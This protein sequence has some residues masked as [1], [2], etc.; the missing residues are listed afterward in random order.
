MLFICSTIPE[1]L[2]FPTSEEG[3][4]DRSAS[5]L[6]VEIPGGVRNRLRQ[7]HHFPRPSLDS[8]PHLAEAACEKMV[9]GF[10][11]HELFWCGE[12]SH[13]SFQLRFRSE[14]IAGTADEQFWL[15]AGLQEVVVVGAIVEGPFKWKVRPVAE[16]FYE[17]EIG[18]TTTISGLV[19]AIWQ[20]DDKL[21]F[22]VAYRH[23]LVNSRPVDEVRA[24]LTFGFTVPAFDGR[25]AR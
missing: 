3:R 19:G 8:F 22:D 11:D 13:Q 12:G 10:D 17:E 14:R 2:R 1:S 5:A 18:Q 7:P 16:F 21:S 6:A 15:G 24:G 25:K 4:L 23:A 20:V 9:G